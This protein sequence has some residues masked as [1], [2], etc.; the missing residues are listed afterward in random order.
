M[1]RLAGG[2]RHTVADASAGLYATV[3]QAPGFLGP[4]FSRAVESMCRGYAAILAR[5]QA[6]RHG[7]FV[8]LLFFGWRARCG[9]RLPARLEFREF[10]QRKARLT[11]EPERCKG[12][13][14]ACPQSRG[15]F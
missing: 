7:R 10:A 11:L 15:R 3:G 8:E 6:R 13:H 9:A 4:G 12:R 1:G 14:A 2:I 5:S